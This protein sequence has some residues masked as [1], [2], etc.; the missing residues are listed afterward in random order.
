MTKF[1][2]EHY[3]L[4]DGWINTWSISD[5]QVTTP[6]TFRTEADAQAALNEFLDDCKE[7]G[8]EYDASEFRVVPVT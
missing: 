5:G 7:G 3:T 8:L 6:E 4:V 1:V 2:V